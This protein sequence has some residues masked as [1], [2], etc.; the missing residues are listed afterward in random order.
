M[1]YVESVFIQYLLT[2]KMYED[3]FDP[4]MKLEDQ[5]PQY[6]EKVYIVILDTIAF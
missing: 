3:C 1:T 6:V 2:E 5:E 4:D